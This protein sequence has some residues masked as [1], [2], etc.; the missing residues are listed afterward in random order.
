MPHTKNGTLQ[1]R[2][3]GQP[4]PAGACT[5]HEP[6]VGTLVRDVEGVPRGVP[7]MEPVMLADGVIE[8][9]SATVSELVGVAGGVAEPVGVIEGVGV[10]EGVAVTDAGERVGEG[11]PCVSLPPV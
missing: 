11:V 10:P 9:V 7:G 2:L 5:T 3:L 6:M 8:G 1:L 4:T